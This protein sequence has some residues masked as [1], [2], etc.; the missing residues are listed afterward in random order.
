MLSGTIECQINFLQKFPQFK[1]CYTDLYIIDADGT[2][3]REVETPWY[4]RKQAIRALFGWMYI[5]GSSMLIERSCFDSVGLFNERF[6]YAQDAEMWL[7]M[8]QHFEI[9]CV[10]EKLLKSR[11]HPDQV[12]QNVEKV[13]A[14]EQAIYRQVFE[15]LGIA[16]IFPELAESAN[17]PQT[18]AWAYKWLGDTMAVRS[19]WVAHAAYYRSAYW[20]Y[21]K[22]CFVAVKLYPPVVGS[23]LFWAIV[24]LPLKPWIPGKVRAWLKWFGRRVAAHNFGRPRHR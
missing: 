18:I 20:E 1:A 12:G 19:L 17:D 5:N 10:P 9:G 8:L 4:P 23:W 14:D 6:R 24:T 21:T 13:V 2:I 3:I 16:Q 15:E 22:W 11:Q 7:R